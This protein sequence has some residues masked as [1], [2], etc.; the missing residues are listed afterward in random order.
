[1]WPELFCQLHPDK[2]AE[3]GIAEGDKVKVET[4]SGA[5]EARAWLSKGIRKT[6]VFVPI[7]WDQHQP[8]HPA[9]TVN[10]LTGVKL[11][12][13]SQQPNLKVHLCRVSRMSQ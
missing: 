3:L 5:I 8:F 2:A 13:I 12:P 10:Y 7:G 11:D 9:P 6:A 1:M 4:V